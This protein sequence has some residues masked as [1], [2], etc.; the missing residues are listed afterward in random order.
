MQYMLTPFLLCVCSLHICFALTVG[1]TGSIP[2]C[3]R[4]FG[5]PKRSSG[6]D[7]LMATSA[8]ATPRVSAKPRGDGKDALRRLNLLDQVG[9]MSLVGLFS[10][11]FGGWKHSE[12]KYEQ[13]IPRK[14]PSVNFV[15]T[16][17]GNRVERKRRCGEIQQQL[18]GKNI[19]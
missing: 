16:L 6:H 7:P 8:S 13:Q 11:C 12:P 19:P 17:R 4:S 15:I 9:F 18:R 5:S 3:F 14:K 1:T 10:N 2:T